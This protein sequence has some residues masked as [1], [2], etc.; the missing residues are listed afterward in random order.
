ML[1]NRAKRSPELDAG[2]FQ[3]PCGNSDVR[4]TVWALKQVQGDKKV[5]VGHAFVWP[6]GTG[7]KLS[8][9]Y[10]TNASG[11]YKHLRY[12]LCEISHAAIDMLA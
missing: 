4:A 11:I 2:S 10:Y 8:A 9:Q 6:E 3:H 7:R 5:N 1:S 12:V